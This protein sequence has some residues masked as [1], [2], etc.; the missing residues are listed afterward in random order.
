MP[1]HHF[2]FSSGVGLRCYTP[3]LKRG[4]MSNAQRQV[5]GAVVMLVLAYP[6]S[7]QQ[8]A[9]EVIEKSI[10]ALGGRA[11]H[12][13]LTSRAANGTIVLGT[14]AGDI[15]GT[16]ELLN[17]PPNRSRTLIKADLSAFGAGDL[18]V[19]QRFDGSSGYVLDSMQGDREITGSQ[20]ELMKN[21]G[22]P[23]PFLNYKDLGTSVTLAGKDTTAGREAYVVVFQPASGPD[24]RTYIDAQ[25]F[26]P[27]QS[28][29]RVDIPQ[30]GQ[31]VD[32]TV[33][34]LD[35]KEVDGVSV[36]FRIRSSSSV[37]SIT[38][39]LQSVEHNVP[40]DASVFVKPGVK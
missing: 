29:T 27:I 22:F 11:A 40:V 18:V 20:L 3:G 16:I 38:I 21:A 13:K 24:T 1:Q 8:S 5:V 2:S 4:L 30:L 14:P 39:T 6:A 10:A 36:P 32:Q 37:Q 12:A 17:A 35:Y 25:T 31:T 26:M 15:N 23:H 9:D 34:F 33:E 28:V 19:D 7:A